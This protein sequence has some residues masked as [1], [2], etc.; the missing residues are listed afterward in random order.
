MSKLIKILFPIVTCL[1]ASLAFSQDVISSGNDWLLVNSNTSGKLLIGTTGNK[2]IRIIAGQNA[3]PVGWTINGTSGDF[4]PLAGTEGFAGNVSFES[5]I[6]DDWDSTTPTIRT[7]DTNVGI[8]MDANGA[9]SYIALKTRSS[10]QWRFYGDGKE[11]ALVAQAGLNNH[12]ESDSDADYFSILGGSSASGAPAASD[13]AFLTLYGDDRGSTDGGAGAI[14][15]IGDNASAKLSIMHNTTEIA[16]IGTGGINL[17][18]GSAASPSYAFLTSPTSGFYYDG[19]V[20]AAVSGTN[21]ATFDSGGL[22]VTGALSTTSSINSTGGQVRAFPGSANN[23]FAFVNDADTGYYSPSADVSAIQAGGTTVATFD[24]GG[25]TLNSGYTIATSGS[26]S[27]LI[28]D[29][30]DD[31]RMDFGSYFISFDEGAQFVGPSSNLLFLGG[32]TAPW[33]GIRLKSPDGSVSQCTVDNS[34]N[35][36]CTGL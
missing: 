35:F 23:G 28:L 1:W 25:V 10:V 5:I 3:T 36:T 9:S 17:E 13:G 26:G 16:S 33:G 12:I 27:D 24:S 8:G 29:A 30:V 18:P 2:D 6:V 21:V 31:I 15:N 19:G 7:S 11:G 4:S 34:D 22:A 32:T 20:R 14:L